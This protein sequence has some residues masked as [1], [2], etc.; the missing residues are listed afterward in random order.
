MWLQSHAALLLSLAYLHYASYIVCYM[1]KQKLLGFVIV[2]NPCTQARYN[3]IY[4]QYM[5]EQQPLFTCARQHTLAHKLPYC[6]CYL[7]TLCIFLY[8]CCIIS[9]F[10]EVVLHVGQV[11]MLV[12]GCIPNVP[13][14]FGVKEGDSLKTRGGENLEKL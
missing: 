10:A 5:H 1:H 8:D 11:P 4:E 3:A 6:R 7:H 2:N 12:P 9:L 14:L 13:L